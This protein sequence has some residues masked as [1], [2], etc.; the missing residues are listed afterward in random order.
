MDRIY[1]KSYKRRS[2]NLSRIFRHMGNSR[3][4][5]NISISRSEVQSDYSTACKK[6]KD[7][8]TC[9]ICGITVEKYYKRK[10]STHFFF[11][12]KE[13]HLD[14]R[15]IDIC[16]SCHA[17]LHSRTSKQ[18]GGEESGITVPSRIAFEYTTDKGFLSSIRPVEMLIAET[19]A[20][21]I[22]GKDKI[23]RKIAKTILD[24]LYTLLEFYLFGKRKVRLGEEIYI[25][26]CKRRKSC[27]CKIRA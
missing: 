22:L 17:R 18:R 16:G 2:R 6:M 25:R 10:S 21:L 19:F 27:L 26:K 4:L 15:V 1:G 8:I 11:K 20:S 14:N 23:D 9:N 3:S 24:E 7:S 12:H 5:G 13:N